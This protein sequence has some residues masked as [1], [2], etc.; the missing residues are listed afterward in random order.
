MTIVVFAAVTVALFARAIYTGTETYQR[1][2]LLKDLSGPSQSE[3]AFF[4]GA[5]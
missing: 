2:R 1:R 3:R 4:G 5:W